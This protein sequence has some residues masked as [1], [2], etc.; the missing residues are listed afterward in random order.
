MDF[1]ILNDFLDRKQVED[2]LFQDGSY[3]SDVKI[4][5]VEI[6]LPLNF[7]IFCISLG[8]PLAWLHLRNLGK[9]LKSSSICEVEKSFKISPA[10]FP[11]I[12]VLPISHF[13]DFLLHSILAFRRLS[14]K[15][16]FNNCRGGRFS[17]QLTIAL[18]LGPSF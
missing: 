15:L 7:N 10:L 12:I 17:D 2:L 13:S 11:L 3:F 9:L 14:L 6:F 5:F 8:Q 4:V 16:N 1:G 18:I